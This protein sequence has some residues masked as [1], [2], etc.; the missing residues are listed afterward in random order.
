MRIE[1]WS[2]AETM[3]CFSGGEDLVVGDDHAALRGETADHS[4][5]TPATRVMVL[6]A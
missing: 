4:P 3:A 5:L 6:G 2:S 1:V